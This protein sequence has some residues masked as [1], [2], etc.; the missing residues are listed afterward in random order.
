M[1]EV[2]DELM[3]WLCMMYDLVSAGVGFGSAGLRFLRVSLQEVA[4]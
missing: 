2:T 3:D 4:I 1:T